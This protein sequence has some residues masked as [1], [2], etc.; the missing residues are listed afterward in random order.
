MPSFSHTVNTTM[1]QL[2]QTLAPLSLKLQLL[3]F[4][5]IF[6][7]PNT[8]ALLM[9][10]KET[11]KL[12]SWVLYTGFTLCLECFLPNIC[13]ATFSSLSTLCLLSFFQRS[14][15][16]SAYFNLLLNSISTHSIPNS[17]F[18]FLAFNTFHP[19]TH[20]L[21]IIAVLFSVVRH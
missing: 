18:F 21:L 12:H 8:L 1:S 2:I 20:Y 15:P 11:G 5:P 19:L 6:T 16:W 14:L 3:L 4:F 7:P 13:M 9:F 17:P 10:F